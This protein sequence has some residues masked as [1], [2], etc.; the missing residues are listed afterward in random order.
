MSLA[1]LHSWDLSPGEAVRVQAELRSHLVLAWDGREI[2][3][4][5][6]PLDHEARLVGRKVRPS[7]VHAAGR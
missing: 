4:I 5:G 2:H 6:S 1:D 7:E 3:T